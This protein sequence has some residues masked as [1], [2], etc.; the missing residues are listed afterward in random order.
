MLLL[1]ALA[2]DREVP[3]LA[4]VVVEAFNRLASFDG[5]LFETYGP[6]WRHVKALPPTCVWTIMNAEDGGILIAS[7]RHFVNRLGYLVSKV[8]VPDG[9]L[10]EV[11]LDA[12]ND[13]E[14]NTHG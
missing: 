6:E 3:P 2:A 8:P 7:G 14:E 5:C 13:N 11:V 12:P 4:G 10:F 1:E 9:I